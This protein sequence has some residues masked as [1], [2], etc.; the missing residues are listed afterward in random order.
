MDKK[1]LVTV[2]TVFLLVSIAMF[3]IVTQVFGVPLWWIIRN[4]FPLSSVQPSKLLVTITPQTPSR[5]G[6]TVTVTVVNSSSRLPVEGA[7]VSLM[8]DGRHIFDYYTDSKGQAFV[9]YLGEVTCVKVSMTG[10]DSI[11]EA[12][13][14]APSRWVRD[15]YGSL[16]IAVVGGFVSGLTTYMFQKGKK[17]S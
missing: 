6:D 3:F 10:F 16:G 7:K 14:N 4:I 9:E 8:K 17:K 13:P 1:R 12:I 2:L 5:I 15:T 11:I